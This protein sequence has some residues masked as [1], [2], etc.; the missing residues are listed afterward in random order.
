[1]SLKTRLLTA[2]IVLTLIIASSI[3]LAL[4]STQAMLGHIDE[5]VDN[6]VIAGH[7]LNVMSDAY[8][9]SIVDTAHKVRTG[10]VEWEEGARLVNESSAVVDR[11]W[12]AFSD[13]GFSPEEAPLAQTA[14]AKMQEAAPVIARLLTIFAQKDAAG[15]E[16][17]NSTQ[18]YQTI[19]PIT[20]A[21]EAL[22]GIQDDGALAE[23]ARARDTGNLLFW[24]Q[25][26][27]AG[28][29]VAALVISGYAIIRSVA[30]RLSI[31]QAALA[32]MANG[33]LDSPVPFVGRNDEIGRIAKAA[34]VFRQSGRKVRELTSAE[35]ASQL[36]N[37]ESRRA[38]MRQ[39]RHAFG[40]VVDASIEGDFSSR[41]ETAFDDEELNAL[42]ASI[43]T[44]VGTVESGLADTEHVLS[45]LARTD[46][47]ARMNGNYQGAFL[48]LRDD[49]NAVAD[50]LT[51]VVGKLRT[52]SGSLRIATSEILTG[53]NDLSLRTTRQA[54]TIEETSAAM[55]Q[56]SATVADNA[57]NATSASQR[58]IAASATAESSGNVMREVT[59]A[60]KR[61]STSSAKISNIIGLIDDIA[62]Q[63]N[64]LALNASVEAARAGEAGKGFAVVAVEVRRLAQSA[65][66]ASS[67]IKGLIDQSG[68]EVTS[69]SHLVDDAA[70]KLAEM[71]DL[72]R[73]SADSMQTIARASGEQASAIAEVNSAVRQM[74]ETTQ[75]NAALV[76]ET[77]AA[78][79]QTEG[80]AAELD[81][82]VSLFR[83]GQE[84]QPQTKATPQAA[85]KR[86]AVPKRFQSVGNA[87]ISADWSEF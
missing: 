19:D 29:S 3:G 17:F 25:M 63:T 12:K 30:G 35:A 24:L 18:L 37:L 61:I 39:L 81:R 43:N 20:N 66:S 79:A 60:M 62:F 70:V 54:A 31:M 47:T 82:I 2:L 72:V 27:M 23:Q 87:A 51:D 83:V 50:N 8:A 58:A 67:E 55:E 10:Q 80:Q 14:D 78:I 22:I 38:M 42:A 26:A 85:P 76:E 21:V 41:V 32:A 59:A 77:N 75:H 7:N 5:L 28:F 4:Y 49:V 46:L 1:M 11:V 56:L 52:T 9:V 34:E 15:L 65:A 69:G 71:L 13:T 45:A 74:D 84:A 57:K 16:A 68:I 44:L 86:P 53:A 73:A 64:L 36:A 40:T 33:D 48:R 6:Y